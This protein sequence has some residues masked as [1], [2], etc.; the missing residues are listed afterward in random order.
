MQDHCIAWTKV[1]HDYPLS[2][3][4]KF[5]KFHAVMRS[6]PLCEFYVHV[7]LFLFPVLMSGHSIFCPLISLGLE[8]LV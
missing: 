4:N 3:G 2:T 5:T 8:L 7:N 6:K 1:P